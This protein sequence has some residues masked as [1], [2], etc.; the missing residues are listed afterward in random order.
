MEPAEHAGAAVQK[1]MLGV[2]AELGIYQHVCYLRAL[3]DAL[4][5][6]L[7][8]GEVPPTGV[9]LAAPGVEPSASSS[10]F[11][12]ELLRLNS[13]GGSSVLGPADKWVHALRGPPGLGAGEAAALL[14]GGRRTVGRSRG[15]CA[16]A[17]P[18]M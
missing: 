2:T 17:S 1:P 3:Q 7:G 5:S 11:M 4:M 6:L 18:A 12:R 15:S 8:Q 13:L 14:R 16:T 9:D 10:S